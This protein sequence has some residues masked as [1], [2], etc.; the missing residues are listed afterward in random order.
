MGEPSHPIEG[1]VV[2]LAGAQASVPLERLSEL[3]AAAQA[4]L[5]DRRDSF[6]RRYETI[7]AAGD[8]RYYLADDGRW[9][10]VGRDL[11]LDDREVKA[12]RRTHASQ[13]RRDGRRLD[14]VEEFE[15]ALDI[16][17]VVAIAPPDRPSR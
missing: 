15:S 13:F 6:A 4:H 12:L 17:D 5:V 8:G 7:E 9:S 3:L 14:R 16:R 10:A 2:L 1:Q 11:E